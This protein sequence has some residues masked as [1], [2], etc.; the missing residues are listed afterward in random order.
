[1]PTGMVIGNCQSEE[2]ARFLNLNIDGY[3]F[4]F[5]RI[6][7]GDKDGAA[8]AKVLDADV[9]LSCVMGESFGSFATEAL[10]KV[11]DIVTH[12][13]IYF[14]GLFPDIATLGV[15]NHRLRSPMGDYHGQIILYGY[16]KGLCVTDTSSLFNEK[17]FDALGYQNVWEE[18]SRSLISRDAVVDVKV[19]QRV[20]DESRERL[21]L[22]MMNHP[23]AAAVEITA[24]ALADRI[25]INLHPNAMDY[26]ANGLTRYGAWAV[27]PLVAEA[28]GLRPAPALY[29]L[30]FS[31]GKVVC[32]DELIAL[33]FAHYDKTG[34]EI[35]LSE[36]AKEIAN[37][38]QILDVV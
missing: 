34:R 23:A 36:A 17:N 18:S 15:M 33:C 10:K 8:Y 5:H 27:H 7:D 3:V 4:D 22:Y 25:G 14:K 28:H 30:P 26:Y 38:A 2:F 24:R 1:M 20:I 11:R 35:V 29:M 31:G 32:Q 37:V 19:A 6:M 16:A 12:T 13:N 21:T 9:V